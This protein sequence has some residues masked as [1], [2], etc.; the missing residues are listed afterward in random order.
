MSRAS[1]ATALVLTAGALGAVAP[2][3]VAATADRV[4]APRAVL[5]L[6][7]LPAGWAASPR[8]GARTPSACAGYRRAR[9]SVSARSNS[10]NFSHLTSQASHAVY[11]YATV[12][13]AR[14]AFGQLTSAP[15]RRCVGA[16]TKT[17]LE[18]LR[19]TVGAARTSRLRIAR[20]GDQSAMDR[21]A[22]DYR[23]SDDEMATLTLD[24]V[25]VREGRGLSLLALVD[26]SATFDARLRARLTS[27]AD[28]RLRRPLAG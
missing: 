26:D 15:A 27:T 6:A 9:A 19:S 25:Y 11:L 4:T 13:R 23:T 17:K 28:R 16:E 10:Q 24:L 1:R 7:D 3:A 2:G 22:V 14:S 8:S 5:R 21:I 18:R 12:R 20:V